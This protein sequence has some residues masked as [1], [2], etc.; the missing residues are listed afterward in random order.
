MIDPDGNNLNRLTIGDRVG[1]RRVNS[2]NPSW[3][4]T[5][6]HLAFS[7]N[8]GGTYAVYLMTSDGGVVRKI[9]PPGQQCMTP[10]WGPKEG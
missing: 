3:S 6:R 4:P 9:S 2:E 1:Q 8:E 10:S 7:A 5:G